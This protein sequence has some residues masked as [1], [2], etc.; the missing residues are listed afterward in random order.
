V[1]DSRTGTGV[2][3]APW[4]AG[5]TRFVPVSAAV[6]AGRPVAITANLTVT[7]AT[8][9]SLLGLRRDAVGTPTYSSLVFGAGQTVASATTSGVDVDG[10]VAI[11][12]LL[13]E[14]EV[15]LDVTGWFAGPE[16]VLG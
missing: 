16:P 7:D 15:I 11:T 8:A 13:G 14:T 2:P 6:P 4:T 3:A 9:A 10:T 12:N 5:E 1:L